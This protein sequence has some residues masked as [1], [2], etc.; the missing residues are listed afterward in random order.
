MENAGV[1]T[2]PVPA[3]SSIV[4]RGSP[5]FPNHLP[6]RARDI[7]RTELHQWTYRVRSYST[8]NLYH[9]F[10]S[11]LNARAS[12]PR[13]CR[14]ALVSRRARPSCCDEQAQAI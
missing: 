3:A 8:R 12:D 7:V 5:H 4:L 2:K 11:V 13:R 1:L 6:W 9:V 14:Q 10:K